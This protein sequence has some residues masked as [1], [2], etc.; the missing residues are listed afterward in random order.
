MNVT[1]NTNITVK[2][3]LIALLLGLILVACGGST[4]DPAATPPEA[5]SS[6][7]LS[8]TDE[9]SEDT[10]GSTETDDDHEH[11]DDTHTH[12]DGV[13]L[14][15]FLDGALAEDVSI[16]DCTLT[17]G[18]DTM[19]YEITVVGSPVN[20]DV[21][22][23][24]P[25]SISDDATTGGLWLD[26]ENSYEIDGPFFTELA[27]IYG[28]ELWNNIYNDDGSVNVIDNAEDFQVA[29]R[30][31]ITEEF[32][33]HCVDGDVAWVGDGVQPTTT[34]QV[35][36]KPV[37]TNAPTLQFAV[38]GHSNLGVTFNGAALSGSADMT[39]ILASYTIAAFDDCGGHINPALGYH[40]H[41]TAGCSDVGEAPEGETAPFA[42]A[43]DGHTIHAPY[44]DGANIEL[45]AC[46]GHSSD[47]YGYHYHANSLEE[48]GTLT[49]VTGLTAE[50]QGGGPGGPGGGPG[51][52]RGQGGA[53]GQAGGRPDFAAAAATLGISE[54][55]LRQALGGPPPDV[56]AGAE[57]LGITVEEL[58]DALAGGTQPAGGVAPPAEAEDS[59][60]TDDDHEH[61]DD[62]HMH[63]GSVDLGLF[64]D[65]ALARDP[66]VVDCTL[67]DGTETVCYEITIVGYPVN[68]DIG[69][70]CPETTDTTAAD[71]GIWFDG[72]GLYDLDGNFI[73]GLAEL[74]NDDNW[75]LYN[76]DGTVNIT[77]T[78]EEFDLAARPN[79]DPSLQNHCVEGRMEWLDGG[80]PVETTVTIPI[81]PVPA[82]AATTGGS[83]G[84]TLNGVSIDA[85]APVDAILS[86]YTI[87]AFD[88]CGGHINPVA[89]YHLHGAR[90]CGEVGEAAAGETPI[91]GYAMDG[92]PI[93]S[94]YSVEQAAA[95]NLDECNGHETD[96]L[97][98]HYH[99]N[100]AEQNSVLT[101]FKGVT[102]VAQAG[103]RG[104]Q[105][106]GQGGRGGQGG[107][108]GGGV[109]FAT[110]AEI[111]GVTE[112][113][114]RDAVGGPPPDVAAAAEILGI[115]EEEIEAAL[116]GQ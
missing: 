94:A 107:P 4:E 69:P 55:A 96:E 80:Q 58:E 8:P 105:G 66:S 104:G 17:D 24:C 57:A 62:T 82:Q 64:F 88:D 56:A 111:L 50:G 10:S 75:K 70:F 46:N 51:G 23:F 34:I 18:T 35:P 12:S 44:D 28:D 98:Y 93:H 84:I 79:V 38:G 9:V 83:W 76:D 101:C 41:G 26:G 22:P 5:T 63:D 72:N 92:Y 47:A 30:P 86:A 27:D 49:C 43:V 113:A 114:L 97:G 73:L 71:A 102:L 11:S 116:G 36:M 29:A 60:E 2:V 89:G 52:G 78:A 68:H 99:A 13:D 61:G 67:A 85:A 25:K 14:G 20:H 77:E 65:G 15:L 7:A 110:A 39:A 53:G 54:D 33:F 42:L 32:Y 106:G 40:V 74:Y 108:G 31:D 103:G 91:F 81:T 95:A 16:V 37:V 112:Q 115:G 45:D 3:G 59:A 100:P 1:S 21:G 6:E 19:C 109:D 87:A 90:G 48:N